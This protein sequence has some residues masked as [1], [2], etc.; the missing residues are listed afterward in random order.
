MRRTGTAVWTHRDKESYMKNFIDPRIA[1][2]HHINWRRNYSETE[3][4]LPEPDNYN[5]ATMSA[6]PLYCDFIGNQVWYRDKIKLCW[7]SVFLVAINI[8]DDFKTWLKQQPWTS[9]W[10]TGKPLP[11][12]TRRPMLWNRRTATE[13]TLEE[14]LYLS[15]YYKNFIA[16][17]FADGH[18][19]FVYRRLGEPRGRLID[20][21]ESQDDTSREESLY[22]F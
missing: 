13:L 18:A 2:A 11:L 14:R 20:W 5:F 15:G 10:R 4:S 22:D 1:I 17:Y 3:F 12:R 7:V 16:K 19:E 8:T 9:Y 21:E 6:R